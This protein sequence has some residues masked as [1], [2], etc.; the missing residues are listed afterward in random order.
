M[1]ERTCIGCRRK[2]EQGEFLRVA[3]LAEGRVVLLDGR[4]PM[5]RSAYVCP[6]RKC[7]EEAMKKGRLARTLKQAITE[8]EIEE[9]RKELEC[10]LR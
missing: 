7:I 5:G 10:K 3:R 9:L 2:G 8:P 6:D 4:Q 1:P